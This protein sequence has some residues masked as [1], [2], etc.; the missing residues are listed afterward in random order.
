MNT[1]RRSDGRVVP[2][3]GPN[4]A[5]ETEVEAREGRRPAKR[6]AL[7]DPMSQTQSW[8][9]D[10]PLAWERIRQAVRRNRK[11]KLTAL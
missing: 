4:K 8:T 9:D 2:K 10:M 7:P 1:P 5:G 3:N 11:E 6:N